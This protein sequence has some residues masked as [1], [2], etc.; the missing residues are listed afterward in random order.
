MFPHLIDVFTSGFLDEAG[1][2]TEPESMIPIGLLASQIILA[3]DPKQVRNLIVAK[4]NNLFSRDSFI[5]SYFLFGLMW[6]LI[7]F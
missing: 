2:T 3:G 6:S 4:K 1:E 5:L 7:I